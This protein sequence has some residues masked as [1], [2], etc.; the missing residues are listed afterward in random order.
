M[1]NLIADSEATLRLTV[2][3]TVLVILIC[4]EIIYPRRKLKLPRMQRWVSNIGISVF[5]TLF[6]KLVFPI[7]G[8]GAA[9]LAQH[10]QWGLLNNIEISHWIGVM[11]FLLVFDL[12]IYFQHRLFHAIPF[13]WRLHR[14]HHTDIDYDVTTGNRFHP[15]SILFS[16]IIKFVLIVLTGAAPIAVLIAEILLNA[17]AMFNHSNLKLPIA[18]DRILRLFIVT[19]DMHRIHHSVEETEHSHNFGFN[20]PWWDRIFGTYQAR[21]GLGHETMEIGIRGFLN[22]RSA[23]FLWLLIQP[24]M[25]PNAEKHFV[26]VSWKIVHDAATRIYINK[27]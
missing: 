4:L 14:M 5:N 20:F 26:P 6:V 23:S 9:L 1:N 17:T 12:T 27:D 15:V 2:F 25:R 3:M 11:L 7:A 22:R 24:L 21:P 13:L 16:S 8:I 19:P 10:K 18:L